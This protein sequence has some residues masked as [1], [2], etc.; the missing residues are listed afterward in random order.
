VNYL[1]AIINARI[2]DY[3]KYL[4]NG[5]IIFDETI[6]T[7]GS[8][9][10]FNPQDATEIID[11]KNNL[12]MP[13]FVSAHTHLYSAF[14]RGLGVDFNPQNFVEVLEQLWWKLDHCLDKEMVYHSAIAF[15]LDQLKAGTTTLIDHHASGEI[16]GSLDMIKKALKDDLGIRSILAFETSDRFDVL[17][18]IKEN[19]DFI[20]KNHDTFT[21]GLFGLHAGFTLSDST[22]EEVKRNL[23]GAGI[24]IHVGESRM[25]EEDSLKKY[26]KTVVKRL[27]DFHLINERSILVHCANVD[28]SELDIIA[29]KKAFIAVNT[30][31]NMNN[32]VGLPDLALM[33]KKGIKVMIGNDGL[34]PSMPIEYLN[35][36]YTAHLKA[37]DPVGYPLDGI[38]EAIINAYDFANRELGTRLG[39]I[40]PGSEADLISV[41]YQEFTPINENN[42]F[43]HLFFGLFP[44]LKPQYVIC[45]G[46]T[47]VN[48]YLLSDQ[49]ILKYQEAKTVAAKL[50][51][52]IS[53]E[54]NNLKFRY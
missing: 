12:V 21:S 32:A 7:V 31:S 2:Y 24:H 52:R 49:M 6:K 4:E 45:N 40:E 15:G 48:D 27:S 19:A 47:L 17:A 23:N 29:K 10:D 41:P 51:Q 14:A 5:F 18:C 13:G 46:K 54:G 35:A 39:R 30:T 26:G 44:N 53:E 43:G 16:I 38:K 11:V 22:L 34:I 42:I 50:W 8:M 36:Y 25:D 1:K 33:R 28:E 9:T 37:E 20:N 3:H